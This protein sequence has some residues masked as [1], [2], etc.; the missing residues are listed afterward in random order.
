MGIS[1]EKP[2][3]EFWDGLKNIVQNIVQKSTDTNE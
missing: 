1:Y 3:K 2:A